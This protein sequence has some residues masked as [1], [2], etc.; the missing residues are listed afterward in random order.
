MAR[1]DKKD[2][3]HIAYAGPRS[4]ESATDGE[5]IIRGINLYLEIINQNGGINGKED[6]L[7]IFDD[8]NDPVKAKEKALET[9]V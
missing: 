6:V 1:V 3:I 8:Q 7:D 5:C 4:G 2:S 9:V